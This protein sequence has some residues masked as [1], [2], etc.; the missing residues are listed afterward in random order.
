MLRVRGPVDSDTDFV[1]ALDEEPALLADADWADYDSLGQLAFARAGV[2]YRCTL[3]DLRAARITQ[4]I[5]L[6]PLQ[7]PAR[8][9]A[10]AA[11]LVQSTSRR[12][13]ARR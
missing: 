3:G 10:D 11:A 7:P 4:S 2:W 6:E 13:Q 12:S 8:Q 1:F 5:D 9:P